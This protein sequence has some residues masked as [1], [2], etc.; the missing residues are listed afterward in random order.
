M[1]A[2]QTFAALEW[3]FG[4]G[5]PDVFGWVTFAGYFVAAYL[6]WRVARS[7]VRAGR[8]GKYSGSHR[9]WYAA[10]VCLVVLGINKQ[11]DLHV[12]ITEIARNIAKADGWYQQRQNLQHNVLFL[13]LV[14]GL[15]V[16]VYL[17][18]LIR[19]APKR[20][21]MAL[22]G[23]IFMFGFVI[24]RS[25]SLHHVDIVLS[26]T[27]S[28][29]TVKFLL[30]FGGIAIVGISAVINLRFSL[31]VERM[32]TGEDH[33]KEQYRRRKALMK[34]YQK[35]ACRYDDERQAL[36]QKYREREKTTYAHHSD[37][38]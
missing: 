24:L 19:R 26:E 9:F 3:H 4:I 13:G 38:T 1:A 36:I 17:A 37:N 22:A 8:S 2:I 28:G 18:H 30:E 16:A 31:G 35:H 10:V 11:L 33:E 15:V 5:D 6:C 7:C 29:V 25:L 32:K 27:F 34:Y 14:F 23:L 20:Q 21:G 12:L